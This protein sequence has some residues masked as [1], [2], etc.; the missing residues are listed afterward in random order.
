MTPFG[1]DTS[2]ACQ[3]SELARFGALQGLLEEKES[4]FLPMP[5]G[6]NKIPLSNT[7]FAPLSSLQ[8][9]KK[10]KDLTSWTSQTLN[11]NQNQPHA[12]VGEVGTFEEAQDFNSSDMQQT[13]V[14]HSTRV[15]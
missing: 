3:K 7:T 10:I 1:E 14:T 2:V 8:L 11:P 4:L 6:L 5:L 9:T 15:L 12:G 13:E